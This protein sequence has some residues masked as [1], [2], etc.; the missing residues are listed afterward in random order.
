[1][2]CLLSGFLFYYSL[3]LEGQ[4]ENQ[5]TSDE[6]ERRPELEPKTEEAQ[7]E[8]QPEEETTSE[9]PPLIVQSGELL[10]KAL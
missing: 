9:K 8:N 4:K 3:F 6:L 10:T 7:S 1:M 5:N 2:L